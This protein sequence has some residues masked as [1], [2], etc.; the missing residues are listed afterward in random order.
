MNTIVNLIVLLS[1]VA[2]GC[3]S[4][5]IQADA[6]GN[7]EANET[8]VSAEA[9]GKILDFKVVEGQTLKAGEVVGYVDTTQLALRKKQLNYSIRAL[10]AKQPDMASQLATVQE[11]IETAK[12]EKKRVENLLR[13]DAATKKQL[14][15]LNAQLA[16]LQKQYNATKTSLAVTT[17]SLQ[18]ETLPLKAQIEQTQDQMQKSV[19]V[20]P[21][22]GTVLTKYM[23]KQEV[24]TV[25]KALYKI[26]DVS[27]LTL[28]VY[29]TGG[30]LP[31]IKL[32]QPVE[33]LVDAP[34]GKYKNYTGTIAWIS[35]K[36][37]FTP[38]TIQTKD[39]RANLVYAI[40]V[41]VKNDGFLKVGMY[42][43]LKLK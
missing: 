24:T 39:E 3:G 41:N 5:S 21:I 12:F 33:V 23:E 20:N 37:E 30:Q 14:D 36:A 8:I 4:S 31:E 13:S 27:M 34:D 43:E 29:I 9:T 1:L 42:G 38:K 25:G 26:A 11:Q 18:S 40:K 16:F 7:F 22:D 15:D 32:N 10:L 6:S 2:Y 28:R 19:I 17:Q 35:D